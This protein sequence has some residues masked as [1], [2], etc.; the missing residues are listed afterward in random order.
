[1]KNKSFPFSRMNFFI[2]LAFLAACLSNQLQFHADLL[3]R[4]FL[5]F[6]F[7]TCGLSLEMLTGDLDL[8]FAAQ[9]SA[10]TFIMAY[11]LER[12]PFWAALGAMLIFNLL[13]GAV[14]GF[15]LAQFEIPSII[16][17]F[18]L[19]VILSNA[20][21][22]LS[23]SKNII[24]DYRME[25]YD[26]LFLIGTSGAFLLAVLL[27]K[28]LLDRTYWGKYCRMIGENRDIVRESGVRYVQAEIAIHVFASLFF[29]AAAGILVFLTMSGSSGTGS[30]F[31]FRVIAAACVGGVDFRTGKGKITG[32]LVGTLS[33]I[34]LVQLLTCFGLLNSLEAIC[35]GII[36]LFS[37]VS[38]GKKEKI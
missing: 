23:D 36:I 25:G 33:I 16:L 3:L 7:M 18:A 31:L 29:T 21:L 10:S 5:T 22:W 30:N 38:N 37:I 19:Q 11:L 17:T 4:Q 15:L 28:G 12:W 1:M 20:F 35:E 27:L 34:M 6:G 2:W 26:P 32:M 9:I 8:S 14:K 13:I 24:L